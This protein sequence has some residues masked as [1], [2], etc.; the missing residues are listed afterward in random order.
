[1]HEHD[2]RPTNPNPE[3]GG[4]SGKWVALLNGHVIGQGGTPEQALQAARQS[5][6]KETSEVV[7]IP[8]KNSLNF[9]PILEVISQHLPPEPDIYLVGGA[10]RD[11][12]LRRTS[13]DLDF[14][15]LGDSLKIAR[16]LAD[17]LG[18]AYFPLDEERDTA[19]LV[20]A[21][22]T[23]ERTYLDFS[24]LRGTSLEDDLVGRDFTINAIAVNIRDREKI[25]DPLNGASDLISRKLRACSS[26]SIKDDPI[27][28]I[29]AIRIAADL[30][31][32]IT[33]DTLNLMRHGLDG[34]SVVSAERIRAELFRIFAGMQPARSIRALDVLG[35]LRYIL[36]ELKSLKGVDQSFPHTADVWEHTLAVMNHLGEI[37]GVL[38][39]DYD[40]DKASNL[41]TGMMVTRLG[42]YRKQITEHFAT[43]L[44][45]DRHHRG[46]LFFAAL[47]HDI[48]KPETKQIGEDGHIQFYEHEHLGEKK[49]SRRAHKLRLS[50]IEVERVSIIIRNHLR[51]IL[52]ANLDG[53]PTRRAVYRFF[54][55]TG[56]AG[57]DI[58]LL[59]L[60][61]TLGT[62]GVRIPAERWQKQLDVIRTLFEA[63]WEYPQD[64]VALTP[65][66]GGEDLLQ[67][68]NLKPGRLIGELLEAVRE[69]QA[70][71][72][73]QTREQS[74]IF[75]E[76]ILKQRIKNDSQDA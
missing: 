51:P 59:A 30:D 28:I 24:T 71:G 14:I 2:N 22:S 43:S 6:H 29:R 65:L 34:L 16:K 39:G 64:Y 20:L 26:M 67:E 75:V 11:A 1:M 44:N 9:P 66:I 15:V 68:F 69:A 58:C 47:Y 46:L 60:A 72:T 7:F 61:D 33:P 52:L 74:L 38:S 42:R 19:R 25:F 10:V 57:V 8:L 18:A 35:V 17:K 5:R 53:P 32:N 21:G 31:L 41:V 70:M 3:L 45:V 49:T 63:W 48:G 13:H 40:P 50:N 37:L 55:D 62:Y 56:L 12:L 76:E 27:R 73:V 23:G 54:R 36:P 4:Y